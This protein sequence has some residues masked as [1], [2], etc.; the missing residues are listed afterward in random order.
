MTEAICLG[1]ER[2]ALDMSV[3]ESAPKNR[4]VNNIFKMQ[5]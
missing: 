4:A 5:F 2:F 1:Y 3:H